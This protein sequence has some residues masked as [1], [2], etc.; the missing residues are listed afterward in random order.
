ERRAAAD[1]SHEGRRVRGILIRV[2]CLLVDL[3]RLRHCVHALRLRNAY[4]TRKLL[5]THEIGWRPVTIL[6]KVT[7]SRKSMVR[8]AANRFGRARGVQRPYQ[9]LL[10]RFLLLGF[11]AAAATYAIGRAVGVAVAG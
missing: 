1:D 11:A 3:G 8:E 10:E 2:A 6:R 7:R 9:V 4:A 5:E